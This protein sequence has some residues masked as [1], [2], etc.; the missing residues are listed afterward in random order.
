MSR[1]FLLPDGKKVDVAQLGLPYHITYD[2]VNLLQQESD[3]ISRSEVD[4]SQQFGPYTLQIPIMSAPMDKFTGRRM[5][6]KL[7]E[8]GGI[9]VLPRKQTEREDLRLIRDLTD[10]NVPFVGSVGLKNGYEDASRLQDSG[11]QVVLVDVAN[12]GMRQVWELAGKIKRDLNM[13]SAFVL[14]AWRDSQENCF[15]RKFCQ[16][17]RTSV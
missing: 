7:A 17:P 9:G 8:L 16:I 11:A 6:R 12:G 3:I 10:E 15:L 4:I 1:E 2:D 13:R 5:V 14:G